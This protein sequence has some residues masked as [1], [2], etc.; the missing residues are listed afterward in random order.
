MVVTFGKRH[1]QPVRTAVNN[2]TR[3]DLPKKE[4]SRAFSTLT[5]AVIIDPDKAFAE[6]GQAI[7]TK[8]AQKLAIAEQHIRALPF[9]KPRLIATS[10]LSGAKSRVTKSKLGFEQS[11]ST[12]NKNY[13]EMIKFFTNLIMK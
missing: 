3:K 5:K 8:P 13:P 7:K 11:I 4:V 2:L 6:L 1:I 10:I 12:I 9:I